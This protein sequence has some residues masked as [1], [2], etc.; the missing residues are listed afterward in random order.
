[1]MYFYNQLECIFAIITRYFIL[2]GMLGVYS[3]ILV[4]Y[5]YDAYLITYEYGDL[6][7]WYWIY[8]H[9]YCANEYEKLNEVAASA[10]AYKCVEV[11]IMKVTFFMNHGVTKD[12]I[13]PQH[14]METGINQS[15]FFWK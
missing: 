5:N 12:R 1:M 4:S 6:S 13:E 2:I 8:D 15:Y 10:L 11:A 7:T 9:R 14:L 3:L